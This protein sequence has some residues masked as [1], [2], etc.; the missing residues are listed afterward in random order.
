MKQIF[1]KKNKIAKN[2]QLDSLKFKLTIVESLL[3]F[4]PHVTQGNVR[5]QNL[6]ISQPLVSS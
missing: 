4:Q 3:L 2:L 6:K 5:K 1:G